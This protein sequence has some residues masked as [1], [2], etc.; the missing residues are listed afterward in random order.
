LHYQRLLYRIREVMREKKPD[1]PFGINICGPIRSETG[2]GEATRSQIR[3]LAAA[4][5]PI[6]L[7]DYPDGPAAG[8]DDEF[9]TFSDEN[10]YA[11]NLVHLTADALKGS[12]EWKSKSYFK[13]HYNIG[14]WSWE[15]PNFPTEWLDRLRNLDE[16]WVASDFVGDAISRVSSIPVVKIPLAIPDR[17]SVNLLSRSRFNLPLKAFIILF[18]FDFMSV[19]YRKNPLGLIQAFRQAFADRNDV[20][21]VLKC[22]HS[23]RYADE[24]NAIKDAC[25]GAHVAIIDTV[26][27]REETTAL[28]QMAD[29]YV[30]L[31]R[32][33]SFGLTLAEAMI[34]EKP[35]IA[36][37]FSGNLEFMNLS[38]SYLVKYKLTEI[39]KDCGPFRGGV[40]EPDLNH[41]AEL[42]LHVFNDRPAAV[43]IAQNARRHILEMFS[44]QR[45]GS[46]MRDRLLRISEL[47]KIGPSPNE[48]KNST[49]D[50]LVANTVFGETDVDILVAGHSHLYALGMPAGTG[51]PV[52]I[53]RA[54]FFGRR[55]GFLEEDWKAHG[56]RSPAYWD[57]LMELAAG[58]AVLLSYGG[59]QH[60]A[61]FL[62][63]RNPPFD[64][65]DREEP[66]L[67]QDAQTVLVPRRLVKAHFSHSIDEL[68][69]IIARLQQAGC[70]AVAV[71][72]TPPP[73]ADLSRYWE[74][75]QEAEPFKVMAEA[76]GLSLS[77]VKLT[78]PSVMLK[79]WRALQ[80]VMAEAAA[81]AGVRFVPAPA[82]STTT[83]GF[84][85]EK[86]H[87]DATHA[88]KAYGRLVLAAATSI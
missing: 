8:M 78:P 3:S 10:P 70:R 6:V 77:T 40:C 15:T 21:L 86:Y 71:L 19:A 56:G 26:L 45:I 72:G 61:D 52:R 80:E 63:E 48:R 65:L 9:T 55:I 75:I 22:L 20:L 27:S 83:D 66:Q 34:L 43:K 69:T 50:P 5:I 74:E 58:K 17:L 25:K 31:H 67:P 35:V 2:T 88:N 47:G 32:S 29:C 23:E 39:D 28:M 13:N 49:D 87:A 85:K 54:Q 7:N 44:E 36:T 1:L 64:F 30:S 24:M 16:I 73:K 11:V 14:Y 33:E 79:L 51:G 68:R 41:A 76:I 18:A 57:R 81:E 12:V 46:M 4:G 62:F 42:M 59:N 84:L 38:N 82:E 37:G 53:L 60:Y